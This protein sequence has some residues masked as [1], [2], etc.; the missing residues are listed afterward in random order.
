MTA[1]PRHRFFPDTVHVRQSRVERQ[2]ADCNHVVGEER[3]GRN[4]KRVRATIECSERGRD[5]VGSAHLQGHDLDA[6]RVGR[7]LNR[8]DLALHHGIALVGQYR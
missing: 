6:E 2:G 5:I 7:C 1:A 8:F 4:V 3:I